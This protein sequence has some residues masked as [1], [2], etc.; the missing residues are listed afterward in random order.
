MNEEMS[1]NNKVYVISVDMENRSAD[2]IAKD[3][4]NQIAA[5]CDKLLEQQKRKV[6][7]DV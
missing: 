3:A 5:L 1:K 4:A 7:Y 2:D 6:V